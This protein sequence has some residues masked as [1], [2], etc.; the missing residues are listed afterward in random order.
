MQAVKGKKKE[1]VTALLS[2]KDP[3]SF[4]KTVKEK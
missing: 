1:S 2:S 3:F 4:R